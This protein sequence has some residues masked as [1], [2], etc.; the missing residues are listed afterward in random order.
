MNLYIIMD[1]T[2]QKTFVAGRNI[3]NPTARDIFLEG[4]RTMTVTGGIGRV[5]KP[6]EDYKRTAEPTIEQ[7]RAA[8]SLQYAYEQGNLTQKELAK[9]GLNTTSV[10]KDIPQ[11]RVTINNVTPSQHHL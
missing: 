8:A 1:D 6:G 7:Q 10:S 2:R 9:Y 5:A 4:Q 11:Q 3:R